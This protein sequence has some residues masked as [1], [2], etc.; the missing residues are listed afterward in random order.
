V[1]GFTLLELLVTIAVSIIL[2]TILAFVMRVSVSTMRDAN[3]RSSLTERIRTMNIRLRDEIG[4]MLPIER[5]SGATYQISNSS[6]QTANVLVF[7]STTSDSGKTVSIDVKYE[8]IPDSA[9][10]ELGRLV[11]YRDATGP[12][13]PVDPNKINPL[14]ALGDDKF[15]PEAQGDVLLVNVR[16]VKFEAVDPPPPS[17]NVL[18]NPPSLPGAIRVTITYGPDVGD[19]QAIESA[20]FCFPVYRGV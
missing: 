18:L 5:S 14:Y 20:V 15:L 12:Y 16:S 17:S 11:R 2:I 10:P 6:G 4:G 1:P 7:A 19:P 8:F 13:D 3:S 9:S